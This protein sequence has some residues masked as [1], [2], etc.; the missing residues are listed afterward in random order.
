[1]HLRRGL[2]ADRFSRAGR[3]AA[4]RLEDME[5]GPRESDFCIVKHGRHLSAGGHPPTRGL[6]GGG[7]RQFRTNSGSLAIL[8]PMQGVGG[9]GKD[10][11]LRHSV[12]R[13]SRRS[14]VP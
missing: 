9:E 5:F 12:T 2:L 4:A 14:A 6:E 11:N 1:M 10:S 13:V 3:K 8:A 7:P